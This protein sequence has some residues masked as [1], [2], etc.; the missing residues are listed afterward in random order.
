MKLERQYLPLILLLLIVQTTTSYAQYAEPLNIPPALSAGFGELRN[1]HFHSG[2]DFKTQL[3]IN[4]PVFAVADGYISRISVSPGGYGLALYLDHP[5]FGHTTVYGH[6]NSFT[7]HI[8]QYVEDKQYQ[9][10]SYRVNLYLEP[11]EIPVA[12]E[13]G[14]AHV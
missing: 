2:I 10:E 14:R 7:K 1:N 3:A 12:K 9:Q 6:L 13:I 4:K 5:E 8:T 11:H